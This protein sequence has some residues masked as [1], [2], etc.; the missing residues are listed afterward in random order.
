MDIFD[1]LTL[2]G[3]LSLFLFGM[4]V[5]GQAL[6]R[7]AG[8]SLKLILGKLTDNK[9]IG[10]LTGFFVTAAI[11]SSSAAT[12]M[13]V[14]FVNSGIMTLRQS[15]SLIMGANVGTTI[16]AWILSLSG[17][18]GGNFFLQMLKP[19]SF[20]PILALIGVVMLL[21]GKNSKTKDSG[22]ILLGFATLMFGLET[23]SAAVSSIKDV[24]AFSNLI[25]KFQNPFLGLLVGAV[26]TALIQSSSATVGILQSFSLSGMVTYAAAIPMIMGMNIGACVPTL[27]SSIGTNKNA[28][29]AAMYHLVFNVLG[30]LFW[31]LVFIAG[32]NIIDRTIL[33]K[34]VNPF[35]IAVV[36]S[37]FKIMCVLLLAP[38]NKYLERLVCRLVPDSASPEK[39]V[40]LD[41]RL[42]K[43]PALALER[44]RILMDDM[45][46]V[47]MESI[48]MSLSSLG[49]YTD[50]IAREIQEKEDLTD[51]YEDVMGT[52]LV[53]LSATK[54]G[55]DESI[56][57][58]EYL[59][60]ISDFERISDHSVDVMKSSREMKDKGIDFTD[61]ADSELSVMIDAIKEITNLAYTAF[62]KGDLNAAFKVEPLEQVV[63]YLKEE[64]RT[65]HIRRLQ[66]GNCSI[67]AG[68]VLNDLLT[69]M[70]R[71]SDHCSNIAGCVID[72]DMNNLN[73][74]Q[75]LKDYK[76]NS[77]KFN[78]VFES[79]KKQ[80]ALPSD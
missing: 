70:Q 1:A 29:R 37:T 52:Y 72:A 36:H 51:H 45:A 25:V 35:R 5:M 62:V 16:T 67:E 76:H 38:F 12:V 22:T 41:E 63:D 71:V 21:R 7:R 55:N 43:A 77:Q 34:A 61:E 60:L 56:M 13:V 11:Q 66:K 53:K 19:S 57:A 28:K 31:L 78:K 59:K 15:M 49:D 40:E 47:S 14:G 68:F 26:L 46:K 2:V 30:A 32:K 58:A 50:D 69:S 24:P 3:G 9:L 79:F 44:C 75:T 80:Y 65:R 54:I 73:L 18:S 33:L 39:K 64:I 6:E 74:H 8:N 27:I 20:T 42:L 23:M 17:I 10:F 48:S 4:N